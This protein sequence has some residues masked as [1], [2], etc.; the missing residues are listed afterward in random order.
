ML[1][2]GDEFGR[3]QYGN[4]NA[5]CQDNEISW[6]GWEHEEW[7]QRLLEFTRRLI[8]LRRDHPVFR[9][10]SFLAGRQ[11]EG[12]GLPDAWWFRPDGRRM[13]QGDW[14]RSETHTLG[15]FLNGDELTETTTDGREIVDDSF[16]LLFNAHFEDIDLRLPNQSFG[17][18]WTLELSTADP[19]LAP[20]SERFPARAMLPVPAR[21]L[22][23][24]KRAP[25]R[26]SRTAAARTGT[27][28][29]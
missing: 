14:K 4:N 22:L 3:A 18:E 28:D 20:S 25:S 29:R 9:R 16:L 13:T 1:L 6:Y 24:L 26:G 8:A 2:G 10:S 21:S 12:S 17:R 15:V 23:L 27:G 19:D 5:W 7:Q 11:L